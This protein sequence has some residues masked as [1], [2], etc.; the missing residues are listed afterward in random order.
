MIQVVIDTNV[1][2]SANLVGAGPS[3]A[4][5]DLATN[6]QLILMCAPPT[7][8]A[9]YEEVPRRPRL[10]FKPPKIDN[11]LSPIRT[12]SRLVHPNTSLNISAHESHNRFYESAEVAAAYLITG[13][14]DDFS[15]DHGPKSLRPT[16][17]RTES[18]PDFPPENCEARRIDFRP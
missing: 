18:C 14:T 16:I 17:S 1:V 5:L 13:N 6:R 10:K 2:V 3:A 9:E 11:A 15:K 7:I 4:I 12:A 8:L